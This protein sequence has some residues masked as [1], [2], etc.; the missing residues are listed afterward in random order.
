MTLNQK[1]QRC[2][3]AQ[4][5][6]GWS[7]GTRPMGTWHSVLA[8]KPSQKPQNWGMQHEASTES[9]VP[10]SLQALAALRWNMR[11]GG[12]HRM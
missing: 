10:W 7:N 11:T 8:D 6:H 3:S 9:C 5:L 4:D 1:K 12:F 2:C